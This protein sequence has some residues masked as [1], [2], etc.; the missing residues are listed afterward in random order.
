MLP[1]SSRGLKFLSAY[2]LAALLAF[3]W[4][5]TTKTRQ[6]FAGNMIPDSRIDPVAKQL[7]AFYPAPQNGKPSQNFIY[8]PPNRED[9]GRINT[10]EDYQFSTKHQ[11]SWIFNSESDDIPASTCRRRHLGLIPG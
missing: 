1:K 9:V 5:P 2:V 7:I 11:I 4:Q 6:V 3:G 8:N 10:R